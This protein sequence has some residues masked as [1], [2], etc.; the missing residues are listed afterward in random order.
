MG[1]DGF[2]VVSVYSDT[3][4]KMEFTFSSK[5]NKNSIHAVKWYPESEIKAVLQIAHGMAEYIDRYDNFARYL[6]KEGILVVGN[7]HLGHGKS[8]G[9]DDE[10]GVV[11]HKKGNE[12]VLGDMHALTTLI[13]KE[14]PDVPYFLLGHSMGSFYTRQ[15]LC[16]YGAE[17]TGAIIMATGHQPK[18][19]VIGGRAIS[20]IISIFKGWNY[21]SQFVHNMAFGSYGKGIDNK[22]TDLDWLSTDSKEVDKYIDDKYCGFVFT[23][24]GYKAMFEG[25]NKLSKKGYLDKMPKELPVLFLAGDGDPV[26]DCGNGV[27]TVFQS[28]KDMGM[29]NAECKIY[30]GMR[31]EILNEQEREIVYNDVKNFILS[32]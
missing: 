11:T 9:S 4:K 19:L 29:E 21:P 31:H 5:D 22:R 3:N 12:A 14:N 24:G 23:L 10:L 17:L 13:K 6:N 32:Q 2:M 1:R 16:E 26:G 30:E 8:V 27:R 7:D 28:F 25:I 20:R 18:G 15:Y